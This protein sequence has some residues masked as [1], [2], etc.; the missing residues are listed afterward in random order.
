MS[1]PILSVNN[2]YKRFAGLVA[3][4][5]LSLDVRA[6]ETHALIGPNGAGKTTLIAQLQG[7]LAPDSGT[8]TFK[9]RDITQEPP[10]RRS[11]LGMA[12]SFQITS[13]FPQ[14]TALANVAL[15]VQAQQGHGFRFWRDAWQDA[16]L[17]QPAMEALSTIGLDHRA[18]IVAED[19]S[20]GER[21]Q[22]ELAMALAMKPSLLLLDEPMAGM[23]RQD[24]QRMTR[25]L[26]GLKKDY[27]ILLVEHD[28][29][30]VFALADRVSVLVAG[31][32]IATGEPQ[33]IRSDAAVKA[34]Y[35]GHRS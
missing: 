7:E 22:L 18:Q 4:S 20:H 17:T 2:L 5:D 21:R 28:M 24:G 14:F 19:L 23:G 30:A 3:T 13:I 15:A 6:G 12:R 25:I 29:D 16:S 27:A 8:I 31:A 34:A 10:H 9:G 1:A 32:I 35:L 26:D 33:S 11:Q